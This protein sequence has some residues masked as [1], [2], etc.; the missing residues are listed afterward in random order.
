MYQAT[1]KELID[2]M[3]LTFQGQAGIDRV[4][5]LSEKN[6]QWLKENNIGSSLRFA[7]ELRSQLPS[8]LQDI[9]VRKFEQLPEEEVVQLMQNGQFPA[10]LGSEVLKKFS[11]F[12]DPLY[13]L[14]WLED[15]SVPIPDDMVAKFSPAI[16]KMKEEEINK[17]I[18]ERRLPG[19]F[20]PIIKEKFIGL[21]NKAP[22]LLWLSQHDENFPE[23]ILKVTDEKIELNLAPNDLVNLIETLRLPKEFLNKN[24]MGHIISVLDQSKIRISDNVKQFLDVYRASKGTKASKRL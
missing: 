6:A 1:Q 24:V 3:L 10:Q 8:E 11:M 12:K 17:L 7:S 21:Q 23:G 15:K 5:S 16:N 20:L 2:N 9:L 4:T 14:K 22:A 18:E 13:V 19:V